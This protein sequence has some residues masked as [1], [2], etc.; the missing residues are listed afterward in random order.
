MRLIGLIPPS[1]LPPKP[2]TAIELPAT[3]LSPYVGSYDLPQ[4][5]LQD[6][7]ALVLH[8]T[9]RNGALYLEPGNFP[10]A[11]LWPEAPTEFFV[12]EVDAQITFT[13]DASGAVTGLVLHQNGEDRAARKLK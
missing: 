13:K 9:I 8:V 5:L 10:V 4:S 6:A 1:A 12:K 7:P 11:R 3:A 2:R